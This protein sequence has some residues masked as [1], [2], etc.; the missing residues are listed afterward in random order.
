MD[1]TTDNG[2]NGNRGN[3]GNAISVEVGLKHQANMRALLLEWQERF[4][5][6]ALRAGRPAPR[7]G[8]MAG[9]PK[10]T[11]PRTAPAAQDKASPGDAKI[12]QA[13]L[14]AILLNNDA[15]QLPA[16]A[17]LTAADFFATAHVAIWS[18]MCE[19][20]K[21]DPLLLRRELERIGKLEIAG[22]AAYVC[23]LTDGIP[24]AALVDQYA[25]EIRRMSKLRKKADLGQ[26]FVTAALAQEDTSAITAQL[27]ELE[28]DNGSAGE[29]MLMSELLADPQA[30]TEPP[31]VLSNVAYGGALTVL[32]APSKGGK[33]TW[34]TDA[35]AKLSRGR[36]WT[37]GEPLSSGALSVL[38][39]ALDEAKATAL[40]RL[41]SRD[42]EADLVHVA[43]FWGLPK[44][45]T[46]AATVRALRPGLVIVDTLADYAADSA[47]DSGSASEWTAVMRP[48]ANLA[49]ETGAAIVALH[50]TPHGKARPRDST[51]IGA[52]ADVVFIMDGAGD[53]ESTERKVRVKARYPTKQSYRVEMT[54]DGAYRQ[55]LVVSKRIEAD[56]LAYVAQAQPCW[57]KDVEEDVKGKASTIRAAISNLLADGQLSRDSDGK[58]LIL[59]SSSPRLG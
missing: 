29:V 45:A 31:V 22:G 9:G 17:A 20:D 43:N 27:V 26:R 46:L 25:R 16:V 8:G 49:R 37:D 59:G 21:V 5:E 15:R 42:A 35:A 36:D 53:D 4:V 44:E 1:S 28:A 58:K 57:R 41:H 19:L 30:L 32:A 23:G 10:P 48:L 47:P 13:L 34:M 52:V 6:P 39:V 2:N 56:V 33:S 3:R 38:W 40:R 50:H 51:A 12:E 24:V 14:G 54:G 18:A 7:L 11:A 55:V